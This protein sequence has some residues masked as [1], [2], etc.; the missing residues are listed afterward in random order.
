MNKIKVLQII[1]NFG[2]GG[3]ERLAVNLMRYLDKK[4]YEVRAISLFGPLNTELEYMLKNDNIPV[5]FLEKKKGFDPRM[6]FRIDRIIKSYRPHII[7]T[8]RYVLKYALPSLLFFKS[9]ATVHTVHNVAEKEVDIV[10]KLVHKVAFSFGVIPVSISKIVSESLTSVY[11]VKNIKLILNGIPVDYYQKCNIKKEEWREKEGFK[12]ED[13][14]FVNIARL[15]P[16]KNQLLIIE[17]FSKGPAK[18]H[19]SHL[20]IVGD[21]YNREMLKK[22]VKM[23]SLE[24]KVHF[25]GIRDDIPDILNASDVFVLSSDWEGNPLSIMEAMAAGKA[26]IATAVGGVPELIQ[27][28]YT[29]ILVPPKDIE[30]LSKAMLMLMESKNLCQKLGEKAKEIAKK[31]FDIIVMVKKYEKLYENLLK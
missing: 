28:N 1:P 13:F 26:V 19:N 29:G 12:K 4:K 5:Y 31:E 21:G 9:F 18:Y 17:A 20:I 15:V 27:D 10:G 30:T 14:L 2:Y 6:F 11:G 25:L 3:A 16:Q 7:H 24:N 23:H 22:I 8:H